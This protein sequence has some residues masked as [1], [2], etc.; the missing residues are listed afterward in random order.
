MA[1]VKVLRQYHFTS[2]VLEGH[3][4][5][6]FQKSCILH[7]VFDVIA[8]HIE[9]TKRCLDYCSMTPVDQSFRC[10]DSNLH[11]LTVALGEVTHLMMIIMFDEDHTHYSDAFGN[12]SEEDTLHKK[13]FLDGLDGVTTSK[14]GA[15]HTIVCHFCPCACSNDDYAYHH[16]AATYLNLQWDCRVCYEFVNRYVSK[17]HEHIQGHMKKS[18]K[19]QS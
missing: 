17:I 18:S 8:V 19:E 12:I 7:W 1:L 5:W 13:Q 3:T 16:L 10:H 4:Q 15:A 9:N 2:N 14:G 11:H 6:K